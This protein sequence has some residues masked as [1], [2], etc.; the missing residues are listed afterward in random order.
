[1]GA[2]FGVVDVAQSQTIM[3]TALK[4]AGAYYSQVNSADGLRQGGNFQ[5]QG[6]FIIPCIWGS[7]PETVESL[8]PKETIWVKGDV[9]GTDRGVQ[10]GVLSNANSSQAHATIWKGTAGSFI[11]LHPSDPLAES[12]GC[13]A[14]RGSQVVGGVNYFNSPTTTVTTGKATVWNLETGT[15]TVLHPQRSGVFASRATATDGSRQA[16]V[17]T[18]TGNGGWHASLWSG[19][20]ESWVD[21]H[22]S[23]AFR[24]SEV[25][26]MDALFQV[27]EAVTTL[28]KTRG[29]L[30]QGT[31]T[32][33]IDMTPSFASNAILNAT[34]DGYH[35]G[36]ALL[37]TG[38]TPGLWI[39]TDPNSFIN[40]G[41]YLP[42]GW[43]GG[44]ALSISRVGDTFY[45]GGSSG[46]P[47]SGR[48]QAMLWTY[49]IPGPGVAWAL[50]GGLWVMARRR[51][52]AVTSAIAS[53]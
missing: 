1:M 20:S 53:R 28:G 13:L 10:A 42:A 32:S 19:T 38:W 44:N 7:S 9:R 22:P 16:G 45:I 48:G 3:G 46:E 29:A 47:E 49:T 31:S 11:D 17:V 6:G 37:S 5:L 23:S 25:N 18:F 4:P 39:G 35:V 52:A 26:G 2:A 40:L 30:W 24:S 33:F 41:Q 50:G 43:H 51:R 27:G 14:I 15:L 8:V 12:S 34:L 36:Q 21:L